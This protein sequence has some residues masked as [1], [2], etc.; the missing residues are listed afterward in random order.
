MFLQEKW[1]SEAETEQ[2]REKTTYWMVYSQL[3]LWL[4]IL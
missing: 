4:S 1:A 3:Q 2:V